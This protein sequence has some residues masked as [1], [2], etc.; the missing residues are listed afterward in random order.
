VVEKFAELALVLLIGSLVTWDG[1]RMPGAEG[2]LL[3]A[4]LLVVVRPAAVF[5]ST[6]GSGLRRGER[7]WIAWF[8]VRGIGSLYYAAVALGLGVLS[9]GEAG[10]V[11]WTVVILVIVSIIVH[12]VTATPLSRRWLEGHRRPRA[13]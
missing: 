2:W 9:G 7:T 6:I 11:F 12:G 13:T 4:L 10:V 8:G 1:L 3:V 5:A